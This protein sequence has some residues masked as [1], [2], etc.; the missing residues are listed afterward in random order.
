MYVIDNNSF[1]IITDRC[2]YTPTMIFMRYINIL[3]PFLD[4]DCYFPHSVCVLVRIPFS[5]LQLHN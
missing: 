2:I 5:T 4:S 3:Q 1:T